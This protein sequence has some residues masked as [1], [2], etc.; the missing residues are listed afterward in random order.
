MDQ[1]PRG[2]CLMKKT[3]GRKSRDTVPLNHRQ[4]LAFLDSIKER[5]YLVDDGL[6]SSTYFFNSSSRIYALAGLCSSQCCGA[7]ATRSRI[8]WPDP[9]P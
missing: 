7:G 2:S 4:I 6:G 3:R 8:F 5:A 9:D 1:G